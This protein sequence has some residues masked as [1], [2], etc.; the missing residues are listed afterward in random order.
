MFSCE[1]GVIGVLLIAHICHGIIVTVDRS[2]EGLQTVP[3]DVATNVTHFILQG[4][5][6]TRVDLN[7]FKRYTK[8]L[9]IDISFNPLS[10]IANGTFDNNRM[11]SV[12][13]CEFCVIEST[14]VSFGPCTASISI[15]NFNHGIVDRNALLNID[16][17]KFIQLTTLVLAGVP[18]FDVN[19]LSLP[20]S[21]QS[22]VIVKQ[23]YQSCPKSTPSGFL[24]LNISRSTLI[25]SSWK[26][27]LPGL[28]TCP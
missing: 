25:T 23:R 1:W 24:N 3:Q 17:T 18:L 21:I 2:K 26:Y 28:P 13:K 11:L 9:F 7:S 5:N 14:P 27:R 6:I 12:I 19:V 8:L 20:P 10:I 4:N 15:M 16:F 22:L